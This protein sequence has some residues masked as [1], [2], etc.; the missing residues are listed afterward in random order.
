[1]PIPFTHMYDLIVPGVWLGS[2]EDSFDAP[3]SVTHILNVAEE[4]DVTE[5]VG[6]TYLKLGARDDDPSED[7][8]RILPAALDFIDDALRG[9]GEVFVHC[10]EGVSRSACVV[11]AWMCTR[12]GMTYEDA[13]RFVRRARPLIDPF[14]AYAAQVRNWVD[15]GPGACRSTIC[16]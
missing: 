5:R 2:F 16:S 7:I 1:M 6:R 12:R 15:L 10:L 9:G 14:P 3:N 4:C 13:I 8:S 11:I